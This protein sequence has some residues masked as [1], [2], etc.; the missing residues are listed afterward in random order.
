MFGRIWRRFEEF[1]IVLRNLETFR[2]ILQK[3]GRIWRRLEEIERNHG[4]VLKFLML[5]LLQLS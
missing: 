4:V 2:E 1:G 3:F 5:I